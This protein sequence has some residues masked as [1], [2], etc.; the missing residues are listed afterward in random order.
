MRP[1]PGAY[2]AGSDG[3]HGHYLPPNY[4]SGG[5]YDSVALAVVRGREEPTRHLSSRSAL[6]P[7]NLNDSNAN[8]T[9]STTASSQLQPAH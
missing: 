7:M 4:D 5:L 1:D 8:A 2:S 6:S 9:V 3:S